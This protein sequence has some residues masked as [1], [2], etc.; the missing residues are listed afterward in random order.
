[1]KLS[2]LN[3][4]D[5]GHTIQISGMLLQ[6]YKDDISIVAIFPE[7]NLSDSGV[8]ETLHMNVDEWKEFIKQSDI[9][10]TEVLTNDKNGLKKIILRKT[11]RSIDSNISW[12]VFKRDGYKCRYCGRDDVP[13]TVDHVM[14]WKNGG[15]S[16]EENLVSSCRK[17]NKV[18]GDIEYDEWIES[19]KYKDISIA[20]DEANILL[21]KMLVTTYKTIKPQI[22]IPNRGKKKKNRR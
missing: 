10:E 7:E 12:R 19:D 13:L 6:N 15:P 8:L 21:N 14:L 5:I 11:A 4:L 9:Q 18:R 17:C 3:L 1:M 22:H 20:L 2:E 16:I